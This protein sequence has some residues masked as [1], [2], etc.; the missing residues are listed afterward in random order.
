MWEDFLARLLEANPGLR[1][2]DATVA[3]MTGREFRRHLHR[4]Y[5]RGVA[6]ANETRRAAD[7][8]ARPSAE[9]LPDFLKGLFREHFGM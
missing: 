4:A 2:D 8:F 1:E 7:D 9:P 3:R 5:A 6:D